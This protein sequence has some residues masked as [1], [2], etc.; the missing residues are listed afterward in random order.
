M[1]DQ[2]SDELEGSEFIDQMDFMDNSD[3]FNSPEEP[4]PKIHKNSK[5][6]QKK[7]K[8]KEKAPK[9]KQ[10]RQ[11]ATELLL[12]TVDKRLIPEGFYDP[13]LDNKTRK[14]MIQMIRNRVSAQ[15]S[16]DKKKAYMAQVEENKKELENENIKLAHENSYLLERVKTLEAENAALKRGSDSYCSKCGFTLENEMPNSNPETEDSSLEQ[17]NVSSPTLRRGSSRRGFFGFSM[18]FAA[19]FCVLLFMNGGSIG[20]F[21]PQGNLNREKVSIL[22][23]KQDEK[24]E[25]NFPICVKIN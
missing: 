13:N 23:R 3:D 20:G 4:E 25:T 5:K 24:N 11:Q 9:G 14:K 1:K 8:T 18:A 22:N 16:R 2:N 21:T 19:I 17:S 15:T 7:D 10:K 6:I 12:K